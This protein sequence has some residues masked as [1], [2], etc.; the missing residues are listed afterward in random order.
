ML[1]G[2]VRSLQKSGAAQSTP[3]EKAPALLT[4][5]RLILKGLPETSAIAHLASSNAQR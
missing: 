5:I 3:L 2:K 4:N 1:V